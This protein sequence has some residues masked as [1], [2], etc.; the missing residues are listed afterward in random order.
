MSIASLRMAAGLAAC[1]LT[2]SVS[3]AFAQGF[4]TTMQISPQ[5]GGR[6]IDALNRELVQGQ[7]L[8]MMDCSNLPAQFFTYDPAN[9]RLSIGGSVS[10]QT[11]ANPAISS[12]SGPA[13]AAPIKSGKP[14]RRAALPGWRA[15]TGVA[16]T[17]AM[18]RRKTG[19]WCK[20]GP[21]AKPSR[22]SSGACSGSR[23]RRLTGLPVDAPKLN[24][25]PVWSFPARNRWPWIVD[26][27]L[28][29][30]VG[31]NAR[32]HRVV[33]VE[34]P[35]GVIRGKQQQLVRAEMI[36]QAAHDVGGIGCVERLD[37][38]AEMI[39]EDVARRAVDPGNLG[40]QAAP[41]LCQPPQEWRDPGHA[42]LDQH[43][44]QAGMF[45]EHALADE[46]RDL[47]LETLRLRAIVLDIIARPAQRG[48]GMAIGAA[49]MMPIGRPCRSAA[50]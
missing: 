34:L 49:G 47:G 4:Q 26:H 39:A 11:A 2:F 5:G 36:E 17:F 19:R 33:T 14:S 29:G 41:Q 23:F 22:T 27:D 31:G 44:L 30:E 20:A 13:T 10:T 8:Q 28:P 16:W 18:V 50:A 12:S 40:A 1:L 48:D 9:N 25:L 45:G 46:A 24:R 37:G 43:H 32:R 15:S 42:G 3:T 38:Q 21:A 6:C 7:R 35:M